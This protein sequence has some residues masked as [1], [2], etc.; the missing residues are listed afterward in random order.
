MRARG[1]ASSGGVKIAVMMK[2]VPVRSRWLVTRLDANG[3]AELAGLMSGGPRDV[4]SHDRGF[5]PRAAGLAITRAVCATLGS[6]GTGP[7]EES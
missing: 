4:A 3:A 7:L 6:N 1:V 5:E 2:F